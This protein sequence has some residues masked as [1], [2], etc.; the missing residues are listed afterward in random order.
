MRVAVVDSSALINLSHL[1]LALE[2]SRFFDLVLVPRSVQREVNKKGKFRYRL[3]KLYETEI[4]QRCA[5]ADETAVRLLLEKN[6]HM[7]EAEALIQAQEQNAAY[8]IGD[9][10]RAREVARNMERKAVGTIRILAR[11]HLDGR[12][13]ETNGLVLKLRRDLHFR[14]SDELVRVAIEMAS[15]PI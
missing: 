3:N 7:G 1:D 10:K 14:V 4:F 12:A 15:E 8:F 5:T 13:P 2:L 11:L 9:E 6:L